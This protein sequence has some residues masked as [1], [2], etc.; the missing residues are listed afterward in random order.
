ME[1]VAALRAVR[2]QNPHRA[3]QEETPRHFA[4]DAHAD[5]AGDAAARHREKNQLPLGSAARR[6]RTHGT[7]LFVGGAGGKDGAVDREAPRGHPYGTDKAL[8]R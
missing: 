7:G 4:E 2:Q 8:D 3:T 5:P 6:V 1:H